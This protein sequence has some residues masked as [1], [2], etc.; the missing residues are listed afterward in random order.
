MKGLKLSWSTLLLIVL[1]RC[2]FAVPTPSNPTLNSI[3]EP[4]TWQIS[5]YDLGDTHFSPEV[6]PIPQ[7]E[8]IWRYVMPGQIFTTPLV[9]QG[10]V[11][12]LNSNGSVVALDTAT[13]EE[14]WVAQP[15]A[16]PTF[17]RF[18]TL[19]GDMVYMTMDGYY[20]SKEDY[21]SPMVYALNKDT[22]EVVWKQKTIS[23][24]VFYVYQGLAYQPGA[25]PSDGESVVVEVRDAANG[26]WIRTLSLPPL[27]F[28]SLFFF[29][30]T[31]EGLY[32]GGRG[33]VHAFDRRTGTRLWSRQVSTASL[34][35]AAFAEDALYIPDNAGDIV[36][37]D[38]RRG[39]ELWRFVDMDDTWWISGGGTAVS[40][41]K[42]FVTRRIGGGAKDALYA[43][44]TER[45]NLLWQFQ[46]EGS[47]DASPVVA[48]GIVY[49]GTNTMLEDKTRQGKLYALNAPHG[50]LIWELE[51]PPIDYAS[52]SI[53]NGVLYIGTLTGEVLAIR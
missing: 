46:V 21:K 32:A 43:L 48:N 17:G 44:E 42:V 9:A 47:I 13:G 26:K 36:A 37:L 5:G 33:D 3:S 19:A 1:L 45:G 14:L 49:L 10:K 11:Y 15:D 7:G 18:M 12:V 22:G 23:S 52:P 30:L 53:V 38:A 41:N 25:S 27:E 28:S 35:Q 31:E 8:I 4:G 2:A 16:Q 50:A 24:G 40:N 20:V 39:T 51:T 34:N 6:A 29:L